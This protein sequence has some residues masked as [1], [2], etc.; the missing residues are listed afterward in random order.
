MGGTENGC[1]RDWSLERLE[2]ADDD[3]FSDLE[4]NLCR[5]CRITTRVRYFSA[6]NDA[7]CANLLSEL[8]HGRYGYNGNAGTVQLFAERCAAARAGPSRRHK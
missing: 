8:R 4:V 5:K 1:T 6:D 7:G 3:L 2:G